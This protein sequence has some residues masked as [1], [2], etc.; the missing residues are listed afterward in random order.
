M[1][2]A[3]SLKWS[4]FAEFAA[5]AITPIVF[6][7][8]AR[9]LTPEDFGVMTAAIMV[10]GFSQIF[11][12]AGM[13]KALIQRQTDESAAAN[14]TFWVNLLLGCVISGALFFSSD[15]IASLLFQDERVGIV[16]QFMT[17]HVMLGALSS[18]PTALLQKRMG[19][20]KL[21]WVRLLTVSIPG[22]A[23][24]PLAWLGFGYWALVAGALVGQGI[25]SIMLWSTCKWAPSCRFETNV[26]LEMGKFGAWVCTSSLLAWFYL[27]AD[28]LVVGQYLGTHDLGLYRVGNQFSTLFFTIAFG[29]ILPV[30][31]S[32][33]SKIAHDRHRIRNY[34]QVLI[35]IISLI[36][37]PAAAV[38]FVFSSQIEVLIFGDE[39]Q[40]VGL[41]IGVLALTHGFSWIVGMNGDIYR[42]IGK[43]SYEAIVTAGTL[44]VYL[45]V[46]VWTARIGFEIFVWGRLCLAVGALLLHL[47]VLW[48]VLQIAVYPILAYA[49]AL[50]FVAFG[51][52]A[53]VE[54]WIVRHVS[55]GWV[56]LIL[57]GGVSALLLFAGL[58]IYERRRSV[59]DMLVLL[60]SR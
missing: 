35:R 36:A 52:S 39:W 15:V 43:P 17:I 50:F 6:I 55:H 21:F 25:Q 7:V 45:A 56:Q 22:F 46:Y 16:L 20:K 5:K 54:W 24:I 38:I 31:Y 2:L 30:L 19:F 18:V 1:S 49:A 44:V 3:H 53:L 26:A 47:W 57:G 29:P 37:V 33:L 42:A 8:L 4:F 14:V 59:E 11:W 34:V 10:V 28:A 48:R 27:W 13:G 12:E 60:K 41:V 23:S 51:V 40:G 32:Y 9:L 58:A